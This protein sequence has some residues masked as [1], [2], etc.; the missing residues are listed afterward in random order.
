MSRE[1]KY[2]GF[3]KPKIED[4][5]V[6]YTGGIEN[7]NRIAF[8]YNK[9][10]V[11]YIGWFIID[12]DIILLQYTGLK[13]KDGNEIYEGDIVKIDG[14]DDEEDEFFLVKFENESARYTLSGNRLVYDFDYIYGNECEVIGNAYDNAELLEGEN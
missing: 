10:Y 4:G 7:I 11:E 9:A 2:R 14:F 3:I 5:E 8:Q 12:V 13:D 6:I 1:I